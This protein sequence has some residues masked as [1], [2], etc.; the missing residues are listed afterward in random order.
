METYEKNSQQLWNNDHPT[1]CGCSPCGCEVSSD[2]ACGCNTVA[3]D[4]VR[5][6]DAEIAEDVLISLNALCGAYA[7]RIACGGNLEEALASCERVRKSICAY[8]KTNL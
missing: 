6:T 3:R 5:L 8:A 2:N 4:R 1:D 7:D